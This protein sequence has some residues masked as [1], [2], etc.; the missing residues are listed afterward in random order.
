MAVLLI[1]HDLKSTT[2]D[3]T[4][5]FN[6]IKQNSDNN[7]WWHFLENTWI[8]N[9][10]LSPQQF[11]NKIAPFMLDTDIAIVIR[12]QKD[13]YGWLPKP[14]WEWLKEQNFT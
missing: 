3:Y 11:W 2:K 1:S 8:V 4:P 6:A 9:T 5:F 7:K 10:Q 14:A 12:V 13:Y